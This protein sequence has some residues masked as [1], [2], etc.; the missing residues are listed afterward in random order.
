M[1]IQAGEYELIAVDQ[2]N[3]IL[4]KN[5][6]GKSTLLKRLD[7]TLLTTPDYGRV[8][9]ITPERGGILI[10]EP[11]VDSSALNDPNW[12]PSTRRNNQANQFRQQT[13]SQYRTLESS[14][15]R[16][17][18]LAYETGTEGAPTFGAIVDQINSLL[19]NISVERA[20]EGHAFTIR[21]KATNAVLTG[22]SISSGEAELI[23]LAIECLVFAANL[24]AEKTNVLLLD[25]PDVHLHPDLQGRLTRFLS[26]LVDTH[27]FTVIVATHSTAML[28]DLADSELASVGLM[29]A[30]DKSLN[31]HKVDDVYRRVLPVFGAHPLSNIFNSAPLLLVE[32]EDDL[33]IWQQAVR[34]AEG[35]IK[36]YPVDCGSVDEMGKYEAL[37]VEIVTAVYDDA[38]AFSLR[39]RDEG[40]EEINDLPPVTRMRLHCRAAENLLLSD[41]VLALAGTDWTTVE[42]KVNEWLDKTPVHPKRDEMQAFKD[43]DFDRLGF[44]LKEIR[45]LLAG[46]MIATNKPWE[47]LV[48]QAIASCR[49]S[50]DPHSLATY[51]GAKSANHLLGH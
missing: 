13:M 40:L 48:G 31:F 25:E 1:D 27:G 11:N 51:L 6:C 41:D 20:S 28:G 22:Q 44:D 33:R 23:S 39:D 15:L 12:M 34:T 10:Y 18:E 45:M 35:R 37:T 14:I 7:E 8:R 5:G 16:A 29:K 3:V 42:A 43:S 49:P 47:V 19:D 9:Y 30:G 26:G 50:V 32:G 46:E 24:E 38:K 17:V 4:G 36:L 2:I 21:S